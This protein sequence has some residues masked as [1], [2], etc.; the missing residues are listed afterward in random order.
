M[1]KK[2]WFVYALVLSFV[3]Q[4][5]LNLWW[6]S[7]PN[8]ISPSWFVAGNI[9]FGTIWISLLSIWVTRLIK[10]SSSEEGVRAEFQDGRPLISLVA[11]VFLANVIGFWLCN[12]RLC[13][14][15]LYLNLVVPIVWIVARKA[16]QRQMQRS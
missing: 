15:L 13:F 4:T 12:F 6:V 1:Q 7:H 3:S 14:F 10:G 9:L 5:L 16:L 2:G 11:S 8:K